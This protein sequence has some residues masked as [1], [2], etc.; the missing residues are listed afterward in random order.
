MGSA[1]LR[2]PPPSC[3]SR[4]CAHPRGGGRVPQ[5]SVGKCGQPSRV[6]VASTARSTRPHLPSVSEDA[7]PGQGPPGPSAPWIRSV[8][9]LRSRDPSP[10]LL[11]RGP[12]LPA[13]VFSPRV[14]GRHRR[15]SQA[16]VRR[17]GPPCSGNRP[18][19]WGDQKVGPQPRVVSVS[20][21]FH[22]W[23]CAGVWLVSEDAYTWKPPECPSAGDDVRRAQDTGLLSRPPRHRGASRTSCRVT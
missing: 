9:G 19:S 10:V 14:P 21:D 8:S 5:A 15:A 12:A 18:A 6:I 7:R 3:R 1:A 16:P 17:A 20:A 13:G 23:V 11:R 4:A 2:T 22:P